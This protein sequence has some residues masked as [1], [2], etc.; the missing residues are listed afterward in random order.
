MAEEWGGVPCIKGI[1]FRTAFQTFAE[2][3]GPFTATAIKEKLP[4]DLRNR[5]ENN[6]IFT[7]NWYP[8]DW[9][10]QVYVAAQE[11]TGLG[12][13]LPLVLSRENIKKDLGRIYKIFIRWLSPEYVIGRAA[14]LF[15]TYYDTG[16]FAIDETRKGFVRAHLTGCHGFNKNIWVGLLGGCEAA[17]IASGVKNIKFTVTKGGGD[18][19]SEME[20]EATWGDLPPADSPGAA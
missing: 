3:Y 15:N 9:Y 4:P 12:L 18:G 2:L 1:A 5:V 20:F 19:E 7:G 10:N 8:L 6:L 11:V 16:T 13:E 17:L 14:R